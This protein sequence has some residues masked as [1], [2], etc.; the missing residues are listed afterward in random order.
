MT[1]K[2]YSPFE[3]GKPV[4]PG[5][6]VGR[7]GQI[8]E[9]DRYLRQTHYGKA[10]A[11]FLV[12]DKGLGKTSLARFIA[13]IGES[14][15]GLLTVHTFLSGVPT[16]EKMA[17][18]VFEKIAQRAKEENV[19]EK[20]KGFFGDKVEEVGAFGINVKFK[21]SD[22]DLSNLVSSFAESL[23]GFIDS[24]KHERSGLMIILDDVNGIVNSGEF[25]N[26]FKRMWDQMSV[27]YEQFP[28][29]FLLIGLPEKRVQL[30]NQQESLMRIF[31]ILEIERLTDEEIE[32]FYTDRFD[33]AGITADEE[34][35]DQM[36]RHCSGL[37]VMMQEIGDAVFWNDTDNHISRL[38]AFKGIA[39]ASERIGKKYL[40]P[41]FYDAVR[42]PRYKSII[43]K[44]GGELHFEFTK[45]DVVGALTESEK[46]V[47]NNFLTRLKGLGILTQP[48]ELPRGAY[49]FTN[50][51]YLVYLF[52][53]AHKQ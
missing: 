37:P 51:L 17:E 40:D 48:T 3:P 31:Q 4:S 11:A 2:E 5:M 26:W 9:F 44:I 8:T 24:I 21:A 13:R 10:Q 15:H 38:D 39:D 12:G 20:V 32:Q 41:T 42:S 52:L 6:F 34:A 16:L 36:V 43:E 1:M 25:A 35:M 49:R 23:I 18:V 14:K 50:R 30:F 27:N 22:Q 45:K 46:K 7:E 28:V 53:K 47:F 19:Y 29:F 33:D